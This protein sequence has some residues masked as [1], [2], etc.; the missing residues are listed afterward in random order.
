MR[1]DRLLKTATSHVETIRVSRTGIN[2]LLWLVGLVTPL[3]MALCAMGLGKE[4]HE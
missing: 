3:A 4:E 1:L 2:P